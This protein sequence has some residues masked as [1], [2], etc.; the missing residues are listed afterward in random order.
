[1]PFPLLALA[2]SALAGGLLGNA[3]T[4]KATP[5]ASELHTPLDIN[6]II[7]DARV[8]AE[9]N[10]AKSLELEGKYLP[11]TAQL[12]S[13]ADFELSKQL[14]G[15]TP[16]MQAR[17]SLLS[18]LGEAN[19]ALKE[20]AASILASLRR[21]GRLDPE[22][23][24]AVVRGALQSAGAAG[25]AG[26]GASRGLVAR[27][28]GLTSLSLLTARQQAALGAG[29]ALSN[30]LASRMGLATGAV[31]A[32]TARVGSLASLI[33]ARALP[34]SGLSPGSIADLYVAENNAADQ[35]KANAAQLKMAQRQA[36]LNAILGFSTLGATL[37]LGMGKG[38]EG[39][40]VSSSPLAMA[41]SGGST[42]GS[43]LT[44]GSIGAISTGLW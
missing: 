27:D 42:F 10:L 13:Q 22:T 19:P 41:I 11:G 5:S 32:D 12:R 16:A 18:S 14:T 4:N 29:S 20:S 9:A 1:M 38:G 15:N 8:N 24:N 39:A 28:L 23:Q 30:D 35:A 17:N 43:G 26:S 40:G 3:L 7:S 37:G 36:K 33:D 31:N 21:G 34:E 2:G 6:K 44:P 25:I